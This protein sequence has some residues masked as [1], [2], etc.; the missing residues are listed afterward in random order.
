MA[1]LFNGS[2][3]ISIRLEQY[4]ALDVPYYR[5]GAEVNP[6]LPIFRDFGQQKANEM[7]GI[8]FLTSTPESGVYFIKITNGWPVPRS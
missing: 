7:D 3:V 1:F 5:G 2:L 8:K 4:L 6:G